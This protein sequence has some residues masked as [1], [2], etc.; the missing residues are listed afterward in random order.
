MEIKKAAL[1]R[2][3]VAVLVIAVFTVAGFLFTL[4]IADESKKNYFQER[5]TQVATAAAAVDVDDVLALEGG[6]SDVSNPAYQRLRAQLVRIKQS[7]PNVRF[8]YLMRPS[9]D[10]LI[11]L[12]D[13]EEPS[14][15]DYSPPGQVFEETVPDDLAVFEGRKPVTV[16]IEEPETDRWG[17]WV[18]ASAYITGRDGKPVALLGTDVDVDSALA[19]FSQVRRLGLTFDLV[20]MVLLSLVALQ[21][22]IW[23]YNKDKREALRRDMEGSVLRLNDEL[24]KTDRMKSDFIQL[25]SHELRG[26]VNAVNLAVQTAGLSLEGKLDEDERELLDVAKSGTRRLVDLVNNLLDLTRLEAGDAL[27]IP[28]EVDLRPLVSST[29]RLFEPLASEKGLR[30]SLEMPDGELE[31]AVDPEAVL[32]V[33]EN[34]VA[35]AIKFTDLGEVE[36]EVATPDNKVVFVVRDTGPGIPKQFKD[37]VFK[38]FS[39]MDV[40]GGAGKRGSGMGL[41]LSKALVEALGGRIWFDSVA[42]RGTDFVF[43][44]PRYPEAPSRVAR[45][46]QAPQPLPGLGH[47]CP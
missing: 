29:V 21:Y 27:I 9:G 33:L 30:L 43:E 6:D 8:V 18:S 12:A 5:R 42:G 1:L 17:T 46:Q 40:P 28:R 34:L 20:A 36:V 13:A 47:V 16:E 35:N 7:D 2:A 31:A 15:T 41:A 39:K 24:V 10:K 44:I 32:R 11:F 14:S 22:M 4:K 23:H 37:E 26:P 38:K 25:A 45:G 3:V 19:G